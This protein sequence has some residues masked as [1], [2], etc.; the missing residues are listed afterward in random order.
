M[1]KYRG[2]WVNC[3]PSPTLDIGN[4]IHTPLSFECLIRFTFNWKDYT[5][6]DNFALHIYPQRIISAL[7]NDF[8]DHRD[9]AHLTTSTANCA[10]GV[11][12]FGDKCATPF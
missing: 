3:T 7:R 2:K 1:M 11:A 9:R 12:H 8:Q 4:Y 10:I 5:S 6:C